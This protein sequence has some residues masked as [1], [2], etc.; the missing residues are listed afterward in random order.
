MIRTKY[1]DATVLI[2]SE[3]FEVQRVYTKSG[4]DATDLIDELEAWPRVEEIVKA[5]YDK[6]IKQNAVEA[7]VARAS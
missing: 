7:A 1:F 6:Q 3:L 2:T 5:E 4:D